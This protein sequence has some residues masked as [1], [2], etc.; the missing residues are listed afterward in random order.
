MIKQDASIII[1]HLILL[2]S[3]SNAVMNIIPAINAMKKSQITKRWCG[4]RMNG[5]TKQFCVEFVRMN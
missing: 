5:T 2:P 3:N 4:R 1:R